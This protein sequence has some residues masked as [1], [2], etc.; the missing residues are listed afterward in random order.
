M[1]ADGRS[2]SSASP[3]M[4]ASTSLPTVVRSAIF[5]PVTLATATVTAAAAQAPDHIAPVSRTDRLPMAPTAPAT[6]VGIGAVGGFGG[7]S[8][9]LLWAVLAALLVCRAA[10]LLGRHRPSVA[11]W[12]P[13]A[14]IS[15]LERPG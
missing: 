6:G 8:F 2:S 5:L 14:F 9:S 11:L 12:R 10:H 13:M 1:A 7:L 15:L 4:A 3:S